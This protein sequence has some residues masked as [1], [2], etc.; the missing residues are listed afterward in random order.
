MI[1]C[2]CSRNVY[3]YVYVCVL[4]CLSVIQRRGT[5]CV[6]QL[7]LLYPPLLCVCVYRSSMFVCVHARIPERHA[8]PR[9]TVCVA[10][11]AF[12]CTIPLMSVRLS[13]CHYTCVCAM[14]LSSL[15]IKP[16]RSTYLTFP[17]IRG[18]TRRE[19]C[20]HVYMPV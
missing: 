11:F 17:F 14:M 13:I 2:F 8:M 16:Y 6:L 12:E 20:V 7:L 19:L 9:S 5:Q 18:L 15:S 4:S 10:T 3:A 1:F